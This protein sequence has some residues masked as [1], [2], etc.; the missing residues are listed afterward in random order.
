MK[1]VYLSSISFDR[2]VH[3]IDYAAYQLETTPDDAFAGF[4]AADKKQFTNITKEFLDIFKGY[5]SD[6]ARGQQIQMIMGGESTPRIGKY[7]EIIR[8]LDY[9]IFETS[10]HRQIVS[11]EVDGREAIAYGDSEEK[12][13]VIDKEYDEDGKLIGVIVE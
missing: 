10:D 8:Y 2:L 4:D 13:F 7:I 1:K 9:G 11:L 3:I 12:S 5:Y 6:I